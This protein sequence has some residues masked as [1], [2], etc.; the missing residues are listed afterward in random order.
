MYLGETQTVLDDKH[1]ITVPRKFR[2]TM[3]VLG[4]TQWYMTKG[5]DGSLFLFPRDEWD[6]IREYS[7]RFP[8]LDSSVV[9]LKRLLYGSVAEVRPDRQGRLP[10]PEH[11]RNY[12]SLD[13]EAVLV[14]VDDHIEIWS[15]S[16][17]REFQKR[18]EPI[19]KE[20]ASEFFADHA[21]GKE[22][23]GEAPDGDSPA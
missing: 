11:L 9:D 14:G 3:E 2:D 22:G 18:T 4:H 10:V 17:W 19:Y 12:A 13:K 6:R 23:K 15:R 5:Y 21:P 7:G 20:M 1:R 8:S 16:G